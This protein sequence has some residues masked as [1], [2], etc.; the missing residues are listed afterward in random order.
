MGR[1]YNTLK[2]SDISVTPV[3]LKY[4]AAYPS[5]SFSSS[6][7][8]INTAN[9]GTTSPTGSYSN[10][11]LLY[12]SVMNMFYMQ[13]ISGSLSGSNC[14]Y[15]PQSTAASGTLDDDYR[16]FP[17]ESNAQVTVISIP[18]Q[19]Y[20]E[21]I[22]KTSFMMTASTGV[23]SGASIT[24][25]ATGSGGAITAVHISTSGSGFISNELVQIDPPYFGG[26][27]FKVLTVGSN[28][29]ILSLLPL[30][31]SGW[32]PSGALYGLIP[33]PASYK[34]VDDG[35]GNILD[36]TGSIKIGNIIYP[37]GLAIIT[38]PSY[39]NVTNYPFTMS[40]DAETTIY[41]NEIRCHINENDFNYST[42]PS[43][44]AT[45]STGV[46]YNNV[47]GSDFVPFATTVGLYNAE[48]ELLIVGKFGMPYPIPSH[49]DV[50]FIVKYDS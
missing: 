49:T 45:S 22:A 5:T 10:E 6:G 24:I 16:Y 11:F 4:S 38:N 30:S 9:N 12:R 31:S 50:S 44:V 42:N 32:T 39:Q 20:G 46:L 27:T 8:T 41:Q 21:N 43:T 29:G 1:S 33:T 37:M 13:Y 36:T 3:K 15:Y 34:F 18:R 25:T 23:G 40:F 14:E 7:I 2:G 35:N 47:T 26:G 19:L 48:N 17:T 28:G